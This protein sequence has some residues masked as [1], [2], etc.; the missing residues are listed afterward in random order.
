M[1]SL[2]KV[3]SETLG[4]IYGGSIATNDEAASKVIRHIFA[5]GYDLMRQEDQ[6]QLQAESLR[7]YLEVLSAQSS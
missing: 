4:T 2:H 1:P 6:C 5:N 3:I 7:Q